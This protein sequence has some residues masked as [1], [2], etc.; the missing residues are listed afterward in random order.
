MVGDL[1]SLIV[2]GSMGQPMANDIA[3]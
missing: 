2:L 3:T 1:L